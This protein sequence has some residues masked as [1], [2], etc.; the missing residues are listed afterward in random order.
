M[1]SKVFTSVI[2]LAIISRTMCSGNEYP[3]C[4]FVLYVKILVPYVLKSWT[5][6]Q[7]IAILSKTS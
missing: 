7:L 2:F 5:I 1:N 4:L 3:A 6:L